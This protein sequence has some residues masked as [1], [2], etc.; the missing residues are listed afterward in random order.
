[1]KNGIGKAVNFVKGQAQK[2]GET[3]QKAVK[4]AEPTLRKIADQAKAAVGMKKSL[5]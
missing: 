3:V 5:M 4:S 2:V 1:M